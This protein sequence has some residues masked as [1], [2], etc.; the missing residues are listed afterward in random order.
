[1]RMEYFE[2][3]AQETEGGIG[4]AV[5]SGN[6]EYRWKSEAIRSMLRYLDQGLPLEDAKAKTKLDT[7]EWI[8][9][10]NAKRP[11]DYQGWVRWEGSADDAIEQ[12]CRDIHQS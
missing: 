10:H 6:I 2:T 1:M 5:G 11:K 7:R 8:K 3:I 4:L 9:N 12:V